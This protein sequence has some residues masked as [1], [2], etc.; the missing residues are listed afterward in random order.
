[1]KS[2]QILIVALSLLAGY[3]AAATLNRTSAGQP[4]VPPI[5][6]QDIAVWRYQLTVPTQGNFDGYAILTDTA[7]GHCWIRHSTWLEK[8][9]WT[10]IGAPARK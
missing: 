2:S 6:G 3:I 10:D 8:G 5:A 4:P 9:Q 1:M 7:T